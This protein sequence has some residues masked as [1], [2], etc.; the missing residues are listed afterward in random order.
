MTSSKN[1][2]ACALVLVGGVLLFSGCATTQGDTL[3]QFKDECRAKQSQGWVFKQTSPTK[4]TCCKAN[5][6]EKWP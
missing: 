5:L 2:F 3:Q 4:A 1:V 6:C